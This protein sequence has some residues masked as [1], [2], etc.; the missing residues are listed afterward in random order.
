MFIQVTCEHILHTSLVLGHP[1]QNISVG[2]FNRVEN[3]AKNEV[4][5]IDFVFIPRRINEQTW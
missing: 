5:E 4:E 3:N 2:H 1:L